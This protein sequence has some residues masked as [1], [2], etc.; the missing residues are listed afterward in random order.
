MHHRLIDFL[1]PEQCA[2]CS[3]PG[4]GLCETCVPP[5]TPPLE[6]R[7]PTLDV[8]ALG[9]YAGPYRSAVHALKDGRRD[10]AQ[11]LGSRLAA[12]VSASDILVPV[13]T[14][15]SRKRVR[16]FDGVDLVSVIASIESR[17]VT[18]SALK[19]IARD[20]Q[21]GRSRVERLCARGRF[22]CASDL[23]DGCT[24]TLVDD[25]CTTGATL[26]DCATV[27]RAAG[28]TVAKAFVVAIANGRA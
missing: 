20:K 13:P 5:S 9:E 2:A 23:V 12:L 4:S 15:S 25:V 26:E 21:R 16:G 3:K 19:C 22:I 24:V 14:T 1:F 28:A 10:V 17:A 18:L 8:L 7:L 6:R 27:L 11:A